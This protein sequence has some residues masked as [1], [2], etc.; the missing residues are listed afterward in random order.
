MQIVA[1][2]AS[3]PDVPPA[4]TQEPPLKLAR[5]RQHSPPH[6]RM[7][8]HPGPSTHSMFRSLQISL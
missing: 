6:T 2:W 5:S 4:V 3:F 7:T 8:G 1:L